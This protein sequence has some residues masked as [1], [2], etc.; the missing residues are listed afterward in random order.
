[1]KLEPRGER[2]VVRRRAEEMSAG[3]IIIVDSVQKRSLEGEVVAAGPDCEVTE[4]GQRVL[5]GQY[6]GFDL[7]IRDGEYDGCLIM[8]EEDILCNMEE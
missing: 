6:S 5:F 2:V 8:N 3:G 4:K 1:M 7:D